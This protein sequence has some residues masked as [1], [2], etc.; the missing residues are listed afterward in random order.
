MRGRGGGGG[1][2]SSIDSLLVTSVRGGGGGGDTSHP[3]PD[4][5]PA[6]CQVLAEQVRSRIKPL[7]K[8]HPA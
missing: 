3:G 5:V 1:G 4:L 6:N 8:N 2:S 7:C